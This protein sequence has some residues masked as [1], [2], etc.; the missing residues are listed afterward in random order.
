MNKSAEDF[1]RE[2]FIALMYGGPSAREDEERSIDLLAKK[3]KAQLDVAKTA[4]ILAGL[5]SSR[6]TKVH[7]PSTQ[8]RATESMNVDRS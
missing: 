2:L 8:L 4:E 7:R 6:A 1:D 3:S 5:K